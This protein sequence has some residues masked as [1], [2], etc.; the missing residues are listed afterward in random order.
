MIEFFNKMGSTVSLRHFRTTKLEVLSLC[1]K[2]Q[3]Q[4]CLWKA[5]SETRLRTLF[6]K[7]TERLKYIITVLLGQWAQCPVVTFYHK[8]EKWE[9]QQQGI[10]KL[11]NKGVE[12]QENMPMGNKLKQLLMQGGVCANLESCDISLENTTH[13]HK[14]TFISR[15]TQQWQWKIL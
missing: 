1:N 14:T 13:P 11:Q 4:K 5:M 6:H 9:S 10:G 7:L 2:W 8:H 3:T 15:F 12:W